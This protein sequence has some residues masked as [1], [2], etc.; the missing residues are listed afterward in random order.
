MYEYVTMK[1]YGFK[2]A[3]RNSILKRYRYYT[4]QP[5]WDIFNPNIDMKDIDGE[6]I[7]NY[8]RN[9]SMNQ[10]KLTAKK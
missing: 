4:L 8:S 6:S 2:G 9:P 7:L 3:L 1:A 10:Y 5:V